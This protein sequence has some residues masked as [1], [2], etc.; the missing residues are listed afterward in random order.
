MAWSYYSTS[1]QSRISA[2]YAGQNI[3]MKNHLYKFDIYFWKTSHE[4]I[5]IIA[6]DFNV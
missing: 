4:N 6:R 5:S 1:R 3:C 2:N